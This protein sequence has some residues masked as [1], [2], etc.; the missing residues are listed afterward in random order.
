MSAPI[1]L[2]LDVGGT[3]VKAV[4][5]SGPDDI[6]DKFTV[7]TGPPDQTLAAL[8]DAVQRF[9][10]HPRGVAAIGV[11]SFGPLDR[12]RR[13]PNYGAILDTPKPLWTGVNLLTALRK[14]FDGPIAVDTDVNGALLGEAAW[15]AAA[16]LGDA[17]YVT[18]GTGIGGGILSGGALVGEPGHPEVGHLL[19]SRT[20][21]E[22]AAF[23]GLCPFHGDCLEGVASAPALAARWGAQPHE[24][25]DDHPAW[26]VAGRDLA[27]LCLALTYFTR[28]DRIIFGGGVMARGVLIERI[29]EA[30]VDLAGGYA[31]H[32]A[33]R[34]VEDYIVQPGLGGDAGALG[35]VRLAQLERDR[36]S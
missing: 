6:V 4:L 14:I 3:S 2:G 23:A 30:F 10:S 28:P 36:Q 1:C 20:P 22:K 21:E 26:R 13:S 7:P 18:V 11:A 27:Q 9:V 12:D 32:R 24:L 8:T 31:L 16:G 34:Q 25:D 29:R 35:G 17:V 5:A 33:A 15:G 19:I